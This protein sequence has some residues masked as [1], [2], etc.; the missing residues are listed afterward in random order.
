MNWAKVTRVC[1]NLLGVALL[2]LTGTAFGGEI[3]QYV[4]GG[5]SLPIDLDWFQVVLASL[6]AVSGASSGISVPFVPDIYSYLSS[7]TLPP[8]ATIQSALCTSGLNCWVGITLSPIS[9]LDFDFISGLG[10]VLSGIDYVSI[11]LTGT[12]GTGAGSSI[13]VTFTPEPSSLVLLISA[14]A[15]GSFLHQRWRI[16]RRAKAMA[17]AQPA[18]RN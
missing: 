18:T 6:P 3:F 15:G 9:G 12:T 7:L 11:P 10:R 14:V 16:R 2:G 13:L 4:S 5:S 17:A 8:G 1:A